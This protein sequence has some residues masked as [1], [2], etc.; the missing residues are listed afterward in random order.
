M[1]EKI[2]ILKDDIQTKDIYFMKEIDPNELVITEEVRNA[3]IKNKCG[4]YGKNF[5]CP[6]YVGEI[7]D[8]SNKLKEYE[9]GFLI[10]VADR[11]FV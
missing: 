9:R 5:M 2:E 7:E 11:G 8:F 10:L 3:C 1:L 6:P 4:Q